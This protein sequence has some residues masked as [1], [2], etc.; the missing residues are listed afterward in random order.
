M[1]GTSL[2]AVDVVVADL[3]LLP[4]QDTRK[5]KETKDLTKET[6][7]NNKAK[8]NKEKKSFVSFVSFVERNIKHY[9]HPYPETLKKQILDLQKGSRFSFAHYVDV[10]KALSL[11]YAEAVETA[12]TQW[13]IE[14]SSVVAV[15]N[16]GQTVFHQQDKTAGMGTIQLGD[17]SRLA[18]TLG[19]RVV[20]D[21]RR[22][23]IAVGGQGAPLLPFYDALRLSHAEQTVVAHNLGGIS[24]VS[25]LPAH[26]LEMDP[27]A[28]DTGLANLWIDRAMHAYFGKPYDE[29][30][31]IARQGQP[32]EALVTAILAHPFHQQHPPK[33]TGRDDFSDEALHA[34]VAQHA[35]DSSKEAIVASLTHATALSMVKAYQA[36]ILPRVGRVDAIF[37]SGGGLYNTYL[38]DLFKTYWQEEGLGVLPELKQPEAVGIPNKAK[39]ALG[40]AWLGWA[41]WHGLPNNVP[42]CTG[43]G[44]YVSGGIIY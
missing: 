21:F 38:M 3:A 11:L 31:T 40:F 4:V 12:L 2:D 17:A 44:A 14:K 32:I 25:V 28:F 35:K 43:A 36:F 10:E 8:E 37:M 7:E 5:A 16:H 6:K 33:S 42:S 24:N 15:C 9:A 13:E 27:F 34:F 39:E 29:D 41:K 30:G 26:A 22:G 23:D 1:S 18:E 19:M 20:A